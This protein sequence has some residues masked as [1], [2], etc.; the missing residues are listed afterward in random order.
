[1]LFGPLDRIEIRFGGAP[2]HLTQPG[3]DCGHLR[4]IFGMGLKFRI[5]AWR[6]EEGLKQV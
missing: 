3:P 6:P 1:M 2:S 4:W 5:V